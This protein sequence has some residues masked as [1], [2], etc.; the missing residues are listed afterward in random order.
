MVVVDVEGLVVE[1]EVDVVLC[2]VTPVKIEE[3]VPQVVVVDVGA[4]V[5]ECEVVL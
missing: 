5:V 4:L 2:R 1:C 3:V